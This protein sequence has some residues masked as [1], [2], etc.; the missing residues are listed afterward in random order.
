MKGYFEI[1]EGKVGVVSL[2]HII[3]MRNGELL[4]IPYED[5]EPYNM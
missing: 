3:V 1:K 2:N 4:M 5:K